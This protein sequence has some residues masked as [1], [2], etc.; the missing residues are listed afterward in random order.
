MQTKIIIKDLFIRG[1]VGINEWERE[2]KQ[3]ILINIELS[4]ALLRGFETDHIDDVINY[5]TLNKRIIDFVENSDYYLLEK[6]TYELAR[7]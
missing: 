3:D 4:L 5:D 2:N 7:L 1:I 6:L